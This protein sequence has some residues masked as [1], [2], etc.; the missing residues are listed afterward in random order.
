MRHLLLLL[1]V[2]AG[3][4]A[5][6]RR[7]LVKS[8]TTGQPTEFPNGDT[9]RVAPRQGLFAAIGAAASYTKTIYLATDSL[10]VY[11]SDGATW[12]EISPTSTAF[13]DNAFYIYDNGD[14]SKIVQWQLGNQTTGTTVTVNTG[15]QT[16]NRDLSYPVM[17]GNRTLAVIDQSQT[18]TADQTIIGETASTKYQVNGSTG[19]YPWEFQASGGADEFYIVSN[20]GGTRVTINSGGETL[21]GTSTDSGAYVLQTQ[22]DVFTSAGGFISSQNSVNGIAQFTSSNANSSS[23]GTITTMGGT[24]SGIADW[25]NSIVIEGVPQSTGHL[26]LGAY[27]NS[28]VFQTGTRT[29]HSRFNS[30]GELLLGT[31]SDSGAHKL[32]VEGSIYSG[33][34]NSNTPAEANWLF[35]TRSGYNGIRQNSSN[36]LAFDTDNTG[37]PAQAMKI[38]QDGEIIL[39]TTADADLGA[40]K[41]QVNGS[42]IAT[43]TIVAPTGTSAN[44]SI[45]MPHGGAPTTPTNG[46]MWTTTGGAFLRMNGLTVS[47]VLLKFAGNADDSAVN[48]TSETDVT[49]SGIGYCG[50]HANTLDEG[51]VI[52]IHIAGT[53][54]TN[55]TPDFTISVKVG[56][57]VVSTGGVMFNT[58]SIFREVS[59]TMYFTVRS[60]GASG[61]LHSTGHLGVAA[62]GAISPFST[63][64]MGS[65][66]FSPTN[67]TLNTTVDNSVSLTVQWGTADVNNEWIT[68]QFV[69]EHL[70]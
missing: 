24:G 34:G 9:L 22:G 42:L 26:V 31:S 1:L 38:K 57:T 39:G 67:T 49:S 15:A 44:S 62:S 37:A 60:N 45:R 6:D 69:L 5:D 52:R 58:S 68:K 46:D 10:K 11:Y 55:G 19:T 47:P 36:E 13:A 20:T 56:S 17:T 3:Y 32:Q 2:L 14:V 30:A 53:I 66:V 48:T 63:A 16:A 54:E 25:P 18:F 35:T 23:Y 12:T 4:S 8:P 7:P 70:Q 29:N 43:N 27:T 33:K 59:G 64:G 21:L 51:D 40:Y 65:I 61:S 50:F 28:L 41:L